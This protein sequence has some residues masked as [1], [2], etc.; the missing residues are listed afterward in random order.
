MAG[1]AKRVPLV[2]GA[3][4]VGVD[5]AACG[6]GRV[7]G[8]ARGASG[9]GASRV[10][11]AARGA[12]RHASGGVEATCG[13]DGVDGAARECGEAAQGAGKGARRGAWEGWVLRSDS[14]RESRSLGGEETARGN[15]SSSKTT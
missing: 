9:V 12:D 13:M 4:V 5:G 3:E 10:D 6:A 2:E 1:S 8:V 15:T 11:G 14:R 7:G